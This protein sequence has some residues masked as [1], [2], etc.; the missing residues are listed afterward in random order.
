MGQTPVGGAEAMDKNIEQEQ[1]G[2]LPKSV[3]SRMSGSLPV[4]KQ[5]RR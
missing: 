1:K 4:T 5:D 2:G 3:A